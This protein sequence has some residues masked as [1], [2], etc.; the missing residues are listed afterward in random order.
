MR[1]RLKEISKSKSETEG[2]DDLGIGSRRRRKSTP[3]E[4][5]DEEDEDSS[6]EESEEKLLKIAID[7]KVDNKMVWNRIKELYDVKGLD[8]LVSFLKEGNGGGNVG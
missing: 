6:I 8:K 7:F 4:E 2:T 3:A 5:E 1:T